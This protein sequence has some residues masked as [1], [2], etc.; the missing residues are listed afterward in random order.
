MIEFIGAVGLILTGYLAL[1]GF[2]GP[3]LPAP[4]AIPVRVKSRRSTQ[5]RS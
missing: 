2:T 3:A 1:R 4:Q 5:A